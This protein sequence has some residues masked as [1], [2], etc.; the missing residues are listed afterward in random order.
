MNVVWHLSYVNMET[1]IRHCMP[2]KPSPETF[3]LHQTSPKSCLLSLYWHRPLRP[4]NW[5][6]ASVYT[7]LKLLSRGQIR[8]T[9]FTGC[10]SLWHLEI[11]TT[12]SNSRLHLPLLSE[13]LTSDAR[14]LLLTA[15]HLAGGCPFLHPPLA[16]RS[17][18]SYLHQLSLSSL[19]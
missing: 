17:P 13:T 4:T 6:T 1:L 8:W 5:D 12:P 3:P 19:T 18:G 11:L 9:H 2:F 14:P 10:W 7:A 16:S 15:C